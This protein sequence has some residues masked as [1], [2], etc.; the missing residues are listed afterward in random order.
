MKT[1]VMYYSKSGNT[2]KVAEAIAQVVGQTS[3]SVPP[4]YPLENVE[5]LFLG[6]GSYGQK[7]DNKMVEFIR[8]LNTN[9]VRNVALFG[10]VGGKDAHLGY[11]RELLT[12][13]GINVLEETYCCKGRSFFF[14]HRKHPN[15]DDLK[16]AQAF[17]QKCVEKMSK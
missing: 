15:A 11:M 5:L 9:R 7:V 6:A 1:K 13:Q 10:T 12:A 2:K 8:T 17:A 14:I 3:E 4:A 16:A